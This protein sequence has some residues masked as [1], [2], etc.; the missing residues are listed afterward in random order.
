MG[1]NTRNLKEGRNTRNF[2]D[3]TPNKVTRSAGKTH[4]I[5]TDTLMRGRGTGEERGGKRTGEITRE[6]T[7][8]TILTDRGRQTCNKK[9][10][11]NIEGRT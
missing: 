5:Y 6:S 10:G 4:T 8:E 2:E 7:E 3:I 9:E 1:E 11:E